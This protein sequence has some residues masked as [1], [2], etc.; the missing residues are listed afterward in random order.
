MSEKQVEKH[1]K[2][3]IFACNKM[4]NQKLSLLLMM[5]I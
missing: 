2:A 3:E 5:V 1:L 4:E